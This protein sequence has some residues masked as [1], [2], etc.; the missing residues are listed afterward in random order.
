MAGKRVPGQR[1][2]RSLVTLE[3]SSQGLNGMCYSSLDENG[4]G[5]NTTLMRA[6]GIIID[7]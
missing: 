6:G 1:A 3:V 5:R 2:R 4:G 7:L